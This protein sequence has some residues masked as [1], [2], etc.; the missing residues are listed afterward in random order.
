MH[1]FA[2]S[3]IIFIMLLVS[4]F[5]SG[6]TVLI[7][8]H[9]ECLLLIFFFFFFCC[10]HEYALLHILPKIFQLFTIEKEVLNEILSVAVFTHVCLFYFPFTELAIT[11][12]YIMYYFEM[13]NPQS[14][15]FGGIFCNL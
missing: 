14:C 7:R 8:P 3:R 13:Q 6:Q 11:W 5:K 4:S 1:I 12:I 10:H 2:I 15:L 9:R